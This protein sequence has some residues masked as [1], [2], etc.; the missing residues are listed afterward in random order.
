MKDKFIDN[1]LSNQQ[2]IINKLMHSFENIYKERKIDDDLAINFIDRFNNWLNLVPSDAKK[3]N[4]ELYQFPFVVYNRLEILAHLYIMLGF[5]EAYDKDFNIKQNLNWICT[6]RYFFN[7]ELDVLTESNKN[8]TFEVL[9][10]MTQNSTV[11][12]S[13]QLGDENRKYDYYNTLHEI[14]WNTD[15]MTSFYLVDIGFY[16]P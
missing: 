9:T 1:I 12:V 5:P 4:I 7:H 11:T 15:N 8:S 16:K 13:F 3:K 6:E 14:F 2:T 10:I